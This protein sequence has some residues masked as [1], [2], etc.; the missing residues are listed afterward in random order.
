MKK[1]QYPLLRPP[2][3]QSRSGCFGEKKNLLPLFG[4]EI[5][6]CAAYSVVDTST[7]LLRLPIFL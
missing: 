6:A 2:G 3:P 7:E 4:I 1:P 5:L